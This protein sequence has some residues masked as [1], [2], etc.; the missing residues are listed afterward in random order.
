MRYIR[1]NYGTIS[2]QDIFDDAMED[3]DGLNGVMHIMDDFI[4]FGEN[5]E[6]NDYALQATLQR[7]REC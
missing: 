4:V 2:A 3:I 6:E 7:F 1:L 5:N